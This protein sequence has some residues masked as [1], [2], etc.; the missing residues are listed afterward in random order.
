MKHLFFLHAGRDVDLHIEK[1]YDIITHFSLHQMEMICKRK[2][3]CSHKKHPFFA[4]K[5]ESIRLPLGGKVS[6][7]WFDG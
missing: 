4:E 1:S 6:N 5:R 3:G 2:N 7:L